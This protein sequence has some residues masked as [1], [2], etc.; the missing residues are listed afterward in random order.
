MANLASTEIRHLLPEV[1][2]AHYEF[3][4]SLFCSLGLHRGQPAVLE[5]LWEKDGRSQTELGEVLHVQPATI[6]KMLNRM[7]QS[8][9]VQRRADPDDQRISR[10]RLTQKAKEIQPDINRY[11]ETLT[12]QMLEGFTI[13]EQVLLRRFLVQIRDNLRKARV[14]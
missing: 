14:D 12:D 4:R 1:C 11:F 5:L 2:R 9:L 10:V 8:G 7:E 6:T 3:V 13:E